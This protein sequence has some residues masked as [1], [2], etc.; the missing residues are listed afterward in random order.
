[1]NPIKKW[2]TKFDDVDIAADESFIMFGYGSTIRSFCNKTKPP[3]EF[4][5][6]EL[7]EECIVRAGLDRKLHPDFV[8]L[9]ER[10]LVNTAYLHMI[11]DTKAL[12]PWDDDCITLLGDSVFK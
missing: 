1:M 10:C 8:N 12:K 2:A 5:S 3:Q 4:T 7:K 11:K 9:V 6:A